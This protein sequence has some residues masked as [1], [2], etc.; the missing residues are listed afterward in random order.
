MQQLKVFLSTSRAV[1][2]STNLPFTRHI[3]AVG[4]GPRSHVD[5]HAI[6]SQGA[7]TRVVVRQ[8]A[9]FEARALFDRSLMSHYLVK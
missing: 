1:K 5:I 2:Y 9:H 7:T 3:V 6:G 4:T 8:V